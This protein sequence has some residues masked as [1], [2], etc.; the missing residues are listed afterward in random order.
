MEDIKRNAIFDK[1]KK[2]RYLLSREWDNKLPKLLFIMLNPSEGNEIIDDKTIKR[3]IYFAKKFNFG[4][5]EIVNLYSLISKSP[6]VLR[7]TKLDPIGIE[8][9]KYILK[10]AKK[11]N[12]IIVAW[13]NKHYINNRNNDIKNLLLNNGF[14]LYCLKKTVKGNPYHPSRIEND[15]KELIEF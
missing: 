3:C 1:T 6:K 11:S 4:S 2:Y 13:G 15:I 7:N 14:K 12:K 9:D 10:A 8:T 5:F